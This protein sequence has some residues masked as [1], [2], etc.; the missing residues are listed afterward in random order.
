[1]SEK[2]LIDA[3]MEIEDLNK[4]YKVACVTA[5]DF[6]H[7]MNTGSRIEAALRSSSDSSEGSRKK[8]EGGIQHIIANTTGPSQFTQS[9]YRAPYRGNYQQQNRPQ[10]YYPPPA[11]APQ[12]YIQ[13]PQQRVPVQRRNPPTPNYPPLPVS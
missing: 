5:T 4:Q 13:I 12:V 3:F 1:M 9:P 11:P 7:L 2:D 10:M 8:K 6:S